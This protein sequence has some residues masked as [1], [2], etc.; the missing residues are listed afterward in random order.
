MSYEIVKSI[1]IQNGKVYLT[2]ADSSLRPL[3]FNR[4][5]SPYLTNILTEE[6]RDALYRKL[7][8]EIWDGNMH[9][10]H[11]GSKLCE[12]FLK[13]RNAFPRDMHFSNFDGKAAGQLLSQMVKALEQ[14]MQAD[15]SVYVA[16]AK[17]MQNDRDYILD[18]AKRT[19]YNYLNHASLDVQSDRAFALEVLHA[20]EGKA[21]FDYPAFYR[22]DKAF[23]MEALKL[24]G[25]FYRELSEDLKSD[26]E[27]TLSAF[28]ESPEKRYHEHLP[29]LIPIDVYTSYNAEA[30][31]LELDRAFLS[32]LL[33][34]CPSI[35]LSRA[36]HLLMDREIAL[37]WAQVGKFILHSFPELPKQFQFD[38]EFQNTLIRRFEHTDQFDALMKRFTAAG[39]LLSDRSLDSKVRSAAS[40]AGN[41][42][43]GKPAPAPEKEL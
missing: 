43:A 3:S 37:K 2:S 23:A 27:I 26:R 6:G 21:W 10:R 17:E 38:P 5:E 36:P 16:K 1:G 15:L 35:H 24:N 34:I 39:I 20:G 40:R 28:E 12:L 25:C 29:D 22:D 8:E 41:T 18:C 11:G 13:A 31:K 42:G 30:H 9:L 33:D 14:D 32:Q 4:W 19:G 7:G